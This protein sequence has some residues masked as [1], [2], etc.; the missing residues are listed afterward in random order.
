MYVTDMRKVASIFAVV[1][2]TT[3][4]GC[5]EQKPSEP[6]AEAKNESKAAA[7]PYPFDTCITD[8]EKLGSM[9]DPYVFVH[10]GQEIKLC[11]KGCIDDFKKDSAKYMK[12]IQDGKPTPKS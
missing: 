11:C 7:K 5:S 8:G 2:L 12:Q 10:E 6:K 9:G 1:A 4:I 3:L